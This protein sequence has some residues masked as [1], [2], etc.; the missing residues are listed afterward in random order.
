MRVEES[1]LTKH[2]FCFDFEVL[3]IFNSE[4][5]KHT[6]ESRDC[7]VALSELKSL[8]HEKATRPKS[9]ERRP[10]SADIHIPRKIARVA[11]L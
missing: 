8:L 7:L 10:Q 6:L 3:L 11:M 9:V 5:H 1:R 2:P 4:K